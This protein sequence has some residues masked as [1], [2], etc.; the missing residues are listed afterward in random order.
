[1][2]RRAGDARILVWL[3]AVPALTF[4]AVVLHIAAGADGNAGMLA[5]LFARR[6]FGGEGGQTAWPLWLAMQWTYFVRN[7]TLP[8]ALAAI[9]WVPVL[10]VLLVRERRGKSLLHLR[11]PDLFVSVLV[12]SGLQGLLYVVVFK[13]SAWF[14]DYWQLFLGPFV[15]A[16]LA[17]LAVTARAAL[18]RWAPRLAW[19]AVALLVVAPAPWLLA[20]LSFY[21]R[22]EQIDPRYLEALQRLR[23]LV[24]RRAPVWTSRRQRMHEEVVGGHINPKANAT[25]VYYADRP[26]L[27]SRDAE[28]VQANRPGCAAYLLG[29]RNQAWEREIAEALKR[30]HRMVPVGD[31]HLIFLPAGPPGEG[32]HP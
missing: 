6:S 2:S 25:E 31:H 15:A 32:G 11:E 23:N 12:V 3:A 30:S 22:H 21:G 7:F 27:F 1:V 5:D 20:S 24:P 17:G 19:L 13:N 26:L 29:V 8:A 18:A 28:E 14:H 4:C 9:L 16:S 10:A